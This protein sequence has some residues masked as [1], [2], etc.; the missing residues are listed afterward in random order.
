MIQISVPL[1][2][3]QFLFKSGIS[4]FDKVFYHP[5]IRVRFCSTF[6]VRI[7]SLMDLLYNDTICIIDN[8]VQFAKTTLVPELYYTKNSNASISHVYT[9]I[10]CWIER[11]KQQYCWSNIILVYFILIDN[12]N[13]RDL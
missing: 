8:S 2:W 13:G 3:N 11:L 9:L 5:S 6:L 10:D 1:R 7:L 12:H 4:A